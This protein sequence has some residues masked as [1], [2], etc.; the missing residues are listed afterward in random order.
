MTNVIIFSPF[1]SNVFPAEQATNNFYH[2]NEDKRNFRQNNSN[3]ATS[4]PVYQPRREYDNSYEEEAQDPE[5]YDARGAFSPRITPFETGKTRDILQKRVSFDERQ[6]TEEFEDQEESPQEYNYQRASQYSYPEQDEG[7]S[8]RQP[9]SPSRLSMAEPPRGK[10]FSTFTVAFGRTESVERRSTSPPMRDIAG[11]LDTPSKKRVNHISQTYNVVTGD[12]VKTVASP[13][14]QRLHYK[15][16][17]AS[18]YNKPTPNIKKNVSS[19]KSTGKFSVASI[20]SK[21]SL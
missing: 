18:T 13:D 20:S 21:L 11:I 3:Q 2:E 17:P 10:Q 1:K 19:V 9:R 12:D 8:L 5:T 6:V 16:E 14:T 4:L 7:Y 15:Y